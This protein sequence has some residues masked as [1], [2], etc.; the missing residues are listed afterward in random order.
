MAFNFNQ[1]PQRL[2]LAI[3]LSMG[4]GYWIGLQVQQY[5]IDQAKVD[6]F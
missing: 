2:P 4:G 3:A 5:F 1:N 6:S